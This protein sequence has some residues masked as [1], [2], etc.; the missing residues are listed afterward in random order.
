MTTEAQKQK[1]IA[2]VLTREYGDRVLD[3]HEQVE[4]EA[5]GILLQATHDGYLHYHRATPPEG[6]EG[7]L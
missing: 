5:L 1:N 7:N 6:K 2:E 3:Y 4:R